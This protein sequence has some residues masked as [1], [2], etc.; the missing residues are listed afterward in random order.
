M[1]I[2]PGCED[3]NASTS[4]YYFFDNLV[5]AEES[6]F[7]L[8]ISMDPASCSGNGRMFVPA[9]DSLTYQWYLNGIALP[10]ETSDEIKGDLVQGFYKVRLSGPNSCSI[11]KEF[12]YFLDQNK[13]VH[14]VRICPGDSYNFNGFLL[15]ENGVYL[16]TLTTI[17]NCDSIVEIVLSV[18]SDQTDTVS[19][20]IFKG[21]SIKVGNENFS[22]PGSYLIDLKSTIGCDSL[23]YLILDEYQVFIPN[24]FS[25][26]DDGHNDEFRITGGEELILVSRLQIFDRWGGVVYDG[27][28]AG[29][30]GNE[31]FWDGNSSNTPVQ[32]GIYIYNI[33]MLFNDGKERGINGTLTLI[34]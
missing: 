19:T 7:G 31:L 28:N 16:D 13:Y 24:V 20:K 2:G 6:K 17:D 33:Q 34:R 27:N 23:V 22:T 21:E 11:T 3:V 29:I 4:I 9:L 1:V 25:P 14:Q 12:N 5:L 30:D 32:A 15:A 8:E 10:G 26:N 18:D